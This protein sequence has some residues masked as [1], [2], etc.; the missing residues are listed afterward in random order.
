MNE[1]ERQ[2]ERFLAAL[3]GAAATGEPIRF[4]WRDDDAVE[5]TPALEQLLAL[6]GEEGAPLSLAVIPEPA[7]PA[8]AQRLKREPK[9]AV[10][11][12]GFA[13]RNHA[14]P[15]E[16]KS[17]FPASRALA[18]SLGDIEA[19]WARLENLFAAPLPVFVP[20]W[21]RI[22]APVAERLA[23]LRFAGLSRYGPSRGVRGERNAHL[24]IVDWRGTRGFIGR[25]AAFQRLAEE[26]EARLAGDRQPVGILT[27][28]LVHDAECWEFCA[29]LV[30][31]LAE[32]PGAAMPAISEI[33]RL[34]ADEGGDG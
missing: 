30:R 23:G 15:G 5:P 28:H 4:F 32:H 33:F 13:H 1:S 24:D 17:E 16:K 27:H 10:L 18:A 2:K 8:L 25:E 29:E 14:R 20:P 9:V 6:F 3:A 34:N 11:Q 21:N 22:A 12:H 19:G 31:L 7:R 26:A